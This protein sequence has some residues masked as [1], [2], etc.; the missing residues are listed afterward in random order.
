MKNLKKKGLKTKGSPLK[1]EFKQRVQKKP[2]PKKG[3]LKKKPLKKGV[4]KRK[5]LKKII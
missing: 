5:G 2:P 3:S 4:Q 1:R